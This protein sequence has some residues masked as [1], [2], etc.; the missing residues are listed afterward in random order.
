MRATAT[1]AD[2]PT[3]LHFAGLPQELTP[4]GRRG[5]GALAHEREQ[6]LRGKE[7][8]PG[9]GDHAQDRLNGFDKRRARGV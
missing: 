6:N 1:S 9:R 3:D 2:M 8:G 5:V 7:H 4:A